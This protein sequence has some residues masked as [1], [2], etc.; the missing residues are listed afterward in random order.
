VAGVEN[1]ETAGTYVT[2]DSSGATY[3]EHL[4]RPDL[5]IG[6]YCLAAG[7][8]DTQDPHDEDEV[9]VVMSGRARFTGG[10]HTID[11]SPGSVFFV[12]AREVHR[13]HDITEDLAVLV[14][15]GPAEGARAT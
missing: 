2:P 9:Y 11:V 4:R 3:E 7:A 15:F 6:T 1:L 10:D 5:S 14:F 13:F 8:D 12:P